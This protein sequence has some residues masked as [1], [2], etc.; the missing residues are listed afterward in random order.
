MLEVE[1]MSDCCPRCGSYDYEVFYSSEVS[2]GSND[3]GIVTEY[4]EC[5][6]C[7]QEFITEAF[8]IVKT[9]KVIE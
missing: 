2:W 5:L 3:E 7:G 9:R 1:P 4:I 8:V 6:D